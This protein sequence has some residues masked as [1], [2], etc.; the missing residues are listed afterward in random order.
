MG[1]A[2]NNNFDGWNTKNIQLLFRGSTTMKY[3][4]PLATA[5]WGQEEHQA[6]Q[7]VIASGMFTM[8]EQV[9]TFEKDFAHFVGSKYCVMVMMSVPA[10]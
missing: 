9:N 8:G 3:K 2:T 6:M 4:F 7:R 10:S 5:T 1:L